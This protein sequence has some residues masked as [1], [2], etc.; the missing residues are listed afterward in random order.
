MLHS[1]NASSIRNEFGVRIAAANN[2]LSVREISQL[3]QLVNSN[4]ANIA[5]SSYLND[6]INNGDSVGLMA[7]YLQDASGV[8]LSNRGHSDSIRTDTEDGLK[9]TQ[10]TSYVRGLAQVQ[11]NMPVNEQLTRNLNTHILSMD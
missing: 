10:M 6:M 8:V 5:R 3:R 4:N 7:T 9:P 1:T 11:Q 2:N